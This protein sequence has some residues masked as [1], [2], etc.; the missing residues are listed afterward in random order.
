MAKPVDQ[1]KQE[2]VRSCDKCGGTMVSCTTSARHDGRLNHFSFYLF[3]PCQKKS[4]LWGSVAL[5]RRYSE[6]Y[7]WA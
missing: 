4:F 1:V 2:Q 5:P 3:P 6:A 7:A